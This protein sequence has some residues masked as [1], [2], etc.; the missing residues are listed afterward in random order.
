MD[1]SAYLNR[2]GYDGA[3][4]P[5]ASTLCALH[6]AHLYAV[7]FENLNIHLHRPIILNHAAL[8]EKIV[9]Q[10]RGGFC[11]EANGMFAWL[12]QQLGFDVT[13]LSARVASE[14]GSFGAEYDHL[15]LSVKCPA[16]ANSSAAYLA[17]V[18]FGDSF[19]EP[20]C[21]D[22]EIEQSDGRRAY[23]IEQ[24]GLY[25]MLWQKKYDGSWEKQYRFTLQP[26]AFS[27]FEAM[28]VYHQTSPDSSF[29]RKRIITRATPRGRVSLDGTRLIVTNDGIRTVQN[30]E[31]SA[32][33]DALL[34]E[35]FGVIL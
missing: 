11:Y 32:Q 7:P 10:Q 1:T 24:D 16:D 18:G 19:V 6:L 23:R 26:R 33:Y 20:L 29:T 34:L 31:N 30:V 21:L 27:E 17:D 22:V 14:D 9:T 4:E 25:R 12:L 3:L 5:N 2:I 13:L 8:Y 35:H 28:C 15:T